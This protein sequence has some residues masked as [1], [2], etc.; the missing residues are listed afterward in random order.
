V[1]LFVDDKHLIKV[2]LLRKPVYLSFLK[3]FEQE[4]VLWCM[5][6]NHLLE[7]KSTNL[8]VL[9]TLPVVD[10]SDKLPVLDHFRFRFA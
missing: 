3:N 4:M 6:L 5:G 9:N 10:S 1:L 2:G 7:K 8:V